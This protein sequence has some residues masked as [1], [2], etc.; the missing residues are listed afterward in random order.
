[1]R[2][3]LFAVLLC[4]SFIVAQDSNPAAPDNSKHTKGEVTVQGC[5]SRSSGDYTLFKQDPGITYELHGSRQ[6]KLRKYLGQR[7]EVTGEENPTM[8][9][10]SD[11][12]NK[13]GSATSV[14]IRVTSI[15]MLDRECPAR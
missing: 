3:L 4:G 11:A 15:R 6:I 8:S 10:S 5:V 9:T 13:T 2:P 7:V 1:M 12:L 14:S